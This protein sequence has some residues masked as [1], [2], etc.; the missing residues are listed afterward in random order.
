MR[1][2][3][4]C[5]G[6]L[7]LL[8]G[9]LP[10]REALWVLKDVAAGEQPSTLKARTPTP[11]RTLVRYA[12][13]GRRHEGDLYLS[14]GEPRA[15][16]VLVPGAA[17]EG[18]DDARLVAFANTLARA[19]FAVLVPE[20]QSLRALKIRPGNIQDVTDAFAYLVSCPE[21]APGGKAGIGAFSYAVGPALLA[22]LS[23]AIRHQVR[24]VLG[25]GGYYDATRVVTYFTTGFFRD[26][27][28]AWRHQ[29]PNPYG[30]W[31]FVLSNVDLLAD[32][33]DR[34]ALSAMAA[35]RLA[36]PTAPIED[37]ARHLKPE[38]RALYDLLVNA[39]PERVPGLLARLPKPIRDDMAALDLSKQDL[40]ALEA[41]VNLLHGKS[42]AVIPYTESLALAAALPPGRVRVTVVGDLGHVELKGLG[43]LDAWQLWLAVDALL[44]ERQP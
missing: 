19:R 4:L 14:D 42:D 43:L 33:G 22:A 10:S 2:F 11:T 44:A 8:Q 5:C 29:R 32:P 3:L 13:A 17:R 12:I 36:D 6:A 18:K 20:I 7:L 15:G 23:P 25:V 38:G 34:E 30:T 35:R 9:C 40:C 26:E 31:V 39:D 37:L 24:F 27:K 41:R 28:G 16:I 21:L 1:R